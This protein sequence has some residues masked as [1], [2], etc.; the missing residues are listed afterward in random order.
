MGFK[1]KTYNIDLSLDLDP[2]IPGEAGKLK[3]TKKTAA[4][5]KE[6]SLLSAREADKL[7]SK[8]GTLNNEE[9]MEMAMESS[10]IQID[11]FYNKGKDFYNP[12]PFN[13]I[14]DILKYLRSEILDV[15]KK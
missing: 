12:L 4:D 8:N 9:S 3:S 14:A 11:F 10:I 7:Q 6:W 5:I 13:V 2:Y 1:A 15:E